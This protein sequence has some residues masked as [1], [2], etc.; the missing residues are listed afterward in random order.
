MEIRNKFPDCGKEFGFDCGWRRFVLALGEKEFACYSLYDVKQGDS[1][2]ICLF[3]EEDAEAVVS[4]G[5]KV[6]WRG[7]LAAGSGRQQTEEL[8]LAEA[9]H[10][11]IR[12][13]AVRGR[14]EVEKLSTSEGH[15]REFREG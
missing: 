5:E 15:F 6:L 11:V 7:R 10:A 14:I 12:I 9:E 3:A 1:L 2:R 4:Q 13:E 8:P